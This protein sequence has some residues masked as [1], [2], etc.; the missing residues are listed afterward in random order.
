MKR[1][2]I[3]ASVAA[4]ALALGAPSA[5]AEG[6]FYANPEFVTGFSG[7][8]S[9]GSSLDLHVGYEQGPFF[10]QLGPALTNN[11]TDTE[12]GWTGK[13]GAAGQVDENTSVYAEVG[14]GKFSDVD[15]STYV[16]MGGKLKL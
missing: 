1:L 7:S 11:T 5:K 14:A 12:W 6:N 15:M 3:A 4:T 8:T 2:L 13:A 10:I 9:T 16:K